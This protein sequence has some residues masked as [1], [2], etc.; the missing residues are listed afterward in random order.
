M[1]KSL[2]EYEN[3]S[4]NWLN[5]CG[6]PNYATTLFAE[7]IHFVKKVLYISFFFFLFIVCC[8]VLSCL[9]L[10]FFFFVLCLYVLYV[11]MFAC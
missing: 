2:K 8:L 4:K 1:P 11:C 6:A 9:V 3:R 7:M 10:S 5:G